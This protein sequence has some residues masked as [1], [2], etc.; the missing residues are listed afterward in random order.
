MSRGSVPWG[1]NRT[2]GDI[3]RRHERWTDFGKGD[4]ERKTM[5]RAG[6]R[7]SDGSVERIRRRLEGWTDLGDDEEVRKIV[8][9]AC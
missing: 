9:K 3:M 1:L 8:G 7:G 5:R 6:A 4:G 2:V